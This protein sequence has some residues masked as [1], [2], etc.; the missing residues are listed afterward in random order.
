MTQKNATQRQFEESL[1]A[2]THRLAEDFAINE[3]GVYI[4][5]EVALLFDVYNAGRE[6]VYAGRSVYN[7]KT[8]VDMNPHEFIP[9]HGHPSP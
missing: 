2:I 9:I 1:K 7:D 4:N 3:D 6:D 5:D 8:T